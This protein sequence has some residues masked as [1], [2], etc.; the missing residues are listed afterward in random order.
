MAAPLTFAQ[1][2]VAAIERRGGVV[3]RGPG[4]INIWYAEGM[5][6]DG[7]PNANRP[8]AF[9]DIRGVIVFIGGEPKILK[10]WEAT[11]Q[12]GRRYTNQPLKDDGAFIIALGQ[13]QC[14]QVRMH[15]NDHLALCQTGGDVTGTRDGN[16]DFRRDGD[17]VSRGPFGINQHWGYDQPKDDI[18]AASAGCLVG[19][20][21]AGHR[22]FMKLVQSD[23]RY[24]A[25]SDYIFKTTIL[26][27][28]DIIGAD[29]PVAIP[30][31]GAASAE[32]R[33]RMAQFIVDYEARR[34]SNG[35][36]GVYMLPDGDGGGSYEVAGINERY[37]PDEAA[38][39][40]GLIREG[41]F[42]EAEDYVR[43]VIAAYTDTVTTWW[44][45]RDADDVCEV[46]RNPGVEFFLRD[47]VFN[48]GPSGAARILQRAVGADEDGIV[49]RRTRA[50]ARGIGSAEAL[51]TRLRAARENYER[52]P[53]GRDESSKF[54]RGLVS[55]W[56]KALDAARKFAAEDVAQDPVKDE[57][58][59]PP[60]GNDNT[61]PGTKPRPPPQMPAGDAAA[62]LARARKT[63]AEKAL[64]IDAVLVALDG[65]LAAI[66]AERIRKEQAKPKPAPA[67]QGAPFRLPDIP[68]GMVR[69][70]WP[71]ITR[72]SADQV[73]ALKHKVESGNLGVMDV[74]GLI[75]EIGGGS[76]KG[77]WP[78][79][80]GALLSIAAGATGTVDQ[81]TAIVA[82]SGF[83]ALTGAAA[84]GKTDQ[85][86][87]QLGRLFTKPSQLPKETDHG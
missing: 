19:R 15:R 60:P 5:N 2:I 26:T 37:H 72:L 40:A 16:K 35:H 10:T 64:E 75:A 62:A 59:R 71:F 48:R 27:A 69:W 44:R 45:G 79:L 65:E 87:A 41:R 70:A 33:R 82:G 9:D 32:Q 68:D 63:I 83:G 28:A 47:C 22:E 81:Q 20:S 25:D 55:R 58:K 50:A 3:D 36:I 1:R 51:L 61:D 12:P 18:G 84:L 34:D 11:T 8:N 13:Q 52:S 21:K 76:G 39:A 49:G 17:K 43:D 67:P 4:E 29:A 57:P 77:F 38:Q 30:V 66:E 56:D 24:L 6:V 7:T 54:W 74:L 53:V 73:V 23:P 86:L 42:G 78:G 80:I 85:V 31:T 14:W 46:L